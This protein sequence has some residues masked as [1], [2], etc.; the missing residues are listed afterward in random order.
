MYDHMGFD[1]S[2]LRKSKEF[3]EKA[4]APLGIKLLAYLEEWAAAGFGKDRPRFWIA[5]GAPTSGMDEVHVCFE[6]KDHAQVKAFHEAAIAAGGRDNG[7]PGPRPEYHKN[8]YGAFVLD[9]D[10]NN[11]EACCHHAESV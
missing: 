5:G 1:V 11:I 3:Y 9:L 7:K 4:L 2:D 6:A 10:G 8:Y